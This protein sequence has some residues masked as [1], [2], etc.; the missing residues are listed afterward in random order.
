M[1]Y[2]LDSFYFVP[3]GSV[4]ESDGPSLNILRTLGFDRPIPSTKCYARAA[5]IVS[6]CPAG[7]GY[8]M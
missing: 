1:R 4:C 8:V 5:E 2:A 7:I 3:L 6:L